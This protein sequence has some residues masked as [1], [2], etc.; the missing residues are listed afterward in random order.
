MSKE[1][2][3]ESDSAVDSTD[4]HSNISHGADDR[5]GVVHRL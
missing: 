1:R 3:R 5:C 4:L 2:E